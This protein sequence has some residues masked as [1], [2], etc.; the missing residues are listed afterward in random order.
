MPSNPSNVVDLAAETKTLEPPTGLVRPN[1][2]DPNAPPLFALFT[3]DWL[4]L[5]TFIVQAL[6]LPITTGD[7]EA[8]Y[9]TFKDEQ[10]VKDCI[11]AMQAVKAL[12]ARFG[13]PLALLKQLASNP[14]ILQTDTAPTEIYTHIVWF[15]TKLYQTATTYNQTLAA[16]KEL[17]DP[18]SC[19]S[20]TECAAVLKEVLTG[21][22]GLQ[23]NALTMV[24][25]AND[26]VKALAQFAVDLKPSTTTMSDYTASSS[27]FYKD[28]E[29]AITADDND[30]KTYQDQADTA[31]KLWKD[32]TI[33]AIT[34]SV[35]TLV[36]SGGMAWPLSAALAGGLGDAAK[37]ARDAYNDA[38]DQR[39]KASADEQKKIDLKADLSGFNDHMAPV[40][41]AAVNFQGSLEKVAGVWTTIAGNIDFIATNFT[42]E[43][44]GS[45]SWVM[46]ALKCEQAT[47]DWQAIAV[48]AQSYTANSLVTYQI[49]P[50]GTPMPPLPKAA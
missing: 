5:Q 50:F 23:S 28:V 29:A 37:K 13:D 12:S 21:D 16:F 1:P 3:D 7:F 48:A 31:Y 46:Q 8:K 11:A 49:H 45:L 41:D 26:L 10:Q 22:G 44:L 30:V 24:A 33:S 38:C 18:K 9:G 32:L 43:K 47:Q 35:G 6:Q 39:N 25:L 40:N 4:T 42:P 34:T 36:L 19:G 15:A 20:P 2:N 17:L 27:T 14:A